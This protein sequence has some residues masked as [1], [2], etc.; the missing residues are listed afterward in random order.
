MNNQ[1][2]FGAESFQCPHYKAV[3]QQRWFSNSSAGD[4]ISTIILQHFMDYRTQ[5]DDYSQKVVQQFIHELKNEMFNSMCRYVPSEFSISTC[6]LCHKVSLWMNNKMVYPMPIIAPSPNIDLSDEIKRI[7]LE[8]A[9]IVEDSAKGAAALLR[10][11]LQKLLQQ[12]GKA[13]KKF[14]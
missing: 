6:G 3:A 2:K 8:A 1:P 5:I 14:K 12:L 13:G 7:Y 11:A 4:V 10:L 9:S